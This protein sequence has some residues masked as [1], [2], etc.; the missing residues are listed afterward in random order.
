MSASRSSDPKKRKPVTK[1]MHLVL[2]CHA[3]LGLDGTWNVYDEVQPKID[4]MLARVA[5]KTG[6]MPKVTYCL[7]CEFITDKLE[8][9][10]RLYESGHEIGVHSHLPGA[11]RKRHSYSGRYALRIDDNGILNQD[12]V[13]GPL[14]QML[15]S[16]GFPAPVSHVAGMFSFQK[17]T[18]KILSEAGFKVD[19]SLIP[20]GGVIK[21]KALG[22]FV[23]ADNRR[24]TVRTPYRPSLEDPWVDGSSSIIELP[25]SGNLGCAYFAM[26][27]AR[28]LDDEFALLE[29]RLEALGGV[30]VYQS[31]WHHFEFSRSL[32]WT[33]GDIGRATDFL[34]KCGTL[35][36]LSFSTAQHAATAIEE[37][38]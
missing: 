33:K 32:N 35:D 2:V 5:D 27:W 8:E 23:I 36:G 28:S 12:M 3:E 30:D 11:H 17:T 31:Y 29:K 19:C 15:I 4:E 13:A 10:I 37:T 21:H 16:L 22:N 26:D 1:E 6:K 38:L 14:R 9:A 25:V 24:R 7:T 20:N 18:I 34:M